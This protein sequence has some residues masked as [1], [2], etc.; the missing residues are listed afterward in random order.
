MR[1]DEDEKSIVA[2]LA[3]I[4]E[5]KFKDVRW[6]IADKEGRTKPTKKCPERPS[7]KSHFHFIPK[8]HKPIPA[9]RALAANADKA[10]VY[11]ARHVNSCLV[12]IW[13]DVCDRLWHDLV[14]TKFGLFLPGSS[15][16]VG[17]ED[18]ARISLL[19]RL[20]ARKKIDLE[21]LR[22][23]VYDFTSMYTKFT[24]SMIKERLTEL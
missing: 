1:Q 4:V 2:H 23:A 19:N 8:P 21:K 18:A 3:E 10:E 14:L 16:L 17:C 20:A 15:A 12:F 11:V 22:F 5:K 24:H 13:A 9:F 7:K 6:F